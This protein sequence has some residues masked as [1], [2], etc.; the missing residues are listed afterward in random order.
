LTFEQQQVLLRR[1][2]EAFFTETPSR[3]AHALAHR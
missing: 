2:T 3:R 1:T